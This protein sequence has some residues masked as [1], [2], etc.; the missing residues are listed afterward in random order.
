MIHSE[1][2][3]QALNLLHSASTEFGFVASPQ[4]KDN[5]KRV[6]TRDGV[7]TGLA[8]L[9]TEDP[10]L[11][12]TFKKTLTTIFTH[13]HAHGFIPSNV[14][15]NG[16]VSY[17]GTAGRADNPSWAVIGLCQYALETGNSS[18][19]WN[20]LDKVEK[21]FHV[22]DI[23]EYNGKHLIYVPQSGDW[24]DEYFYHGYILFDQ[25]LRVW[26]LELASTIFQRAEWAQKASQIRDTVRRNFRP[27]S[28]TSGL[29]AKNLEHQRPHA[30]SEYWSMGF[31]PSTVY[32]QFD[33]QANALALLL[34]IGDE[35]ENRQLIEFLT[36]L[37]DK[38]ER[39]LPSFYPP[40]IENDPEMHELR[41][42]HAYGFRNYPHQFHN[43]GLWPVW[44]GFTV[45]A[46]MYHKETGLAERIMAAINT[47]NEAGQ[48]SFNECMEG[49]TG[50]PTGVSFC[51]WSAAG[52]VIAAN[53]VNGRT[54]MKPNKRSHAKIN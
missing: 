35:H 40:V 49:T 5:Y 52:A 26:A 9:A 23:W 18:F 33:L 43:G 20:Y 41:N 31:N 2:Y 7:V 22:L 17:G 39:M 51:T 47:A 11:I 34:D 29:Y 37:H 13:Q 30:P 46:L 16:T 27:G 6:W 14:T 24:A 45:A 32:R 19:A 28:T 38:Y 1:G 4:E 3:N 48:W 44:N 36:T 54:L 8:A 12:E 50:G 21:S 25:L 53:A 10:R 15:E 42:N